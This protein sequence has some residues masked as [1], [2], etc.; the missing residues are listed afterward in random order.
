MEG[1][2]RVGV[3]FGGKAAVHEVSLGSAKSIREAID[4]NTLDSFSYLRINSL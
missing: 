2:I 3:T 4:K 1:K